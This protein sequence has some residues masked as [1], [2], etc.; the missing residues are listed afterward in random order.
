MIFSLSRWVMDSSHDS[1]V[2]QMAYLLVRLIP[3]DLGNVIGHIGD[4]SKYSFFVCVRL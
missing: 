4:S 1:P 2:T 3:K